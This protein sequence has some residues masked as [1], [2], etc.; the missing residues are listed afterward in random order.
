MYASANNLSRQNNVGHLLFKHAGAAVIFNIVNG[1][2]PSG[3]VVKIKNV[4]FI[5]PDY[6]N[7][8]DLNFYQSDDDAEGRTK[9]RYDLEKGNWPT[10]VDERN[11][12]TLRTVG[13]L[14]IDNSR[15]NLTAKWTLPTGYLSN[16]T[17]YMKDE[18]HYTFDFTSSSISALNVLPG[19]ASPSFQNDPEFY[20]STDASAW[21]QYG[22]PL[23][24]PVQS[25]ANAYL[26]YQICN[27]PSAGYYLYDLNLPRGIWQAGHVYIYNIYPHFTG[28]KFTI[29]V[30]PWEY[31][32]SNF[33]F[34][35]LENWEYLS[36]GTVTP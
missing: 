33:N 34:D 7:N 4:L 31:L 14:T 11:Q 6:D 17:S 13:T 35:Y 8:G 18:D 19:S 16:Y 2:V 25:V 30:E 1:G 21:L 5:N 15:V 20:L 3:D 22:N 10:I 12:I 9:V 24:I 23:M 28:A 29:E 32:A 26:W 27:G 36:S